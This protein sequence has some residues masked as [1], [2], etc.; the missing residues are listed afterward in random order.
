MAHERVLT[1]D[2][3]RFLRGGREHRIVSAAIHY[4]RIHPDLWRDRLQRLRAMGCNTVECYIAWNFHQPTPAAP[5][6]DGWRD[7]AGFV[8]LAG[9]LG[10]DVIARPG[11]YICAEWDFGGLPAWLLAD[12]NVRLRT[13][14]PVYLAAVDAWFDEL[15][16][17]LAELQATR[18]GP[19]VAVQIENEYGSFGADPDYLDHLRK[20]LIERGVDTLLFTSDGPQELMLAG[21][22]VPDV[23]ATVNFGSRADEAFATL[24]RV[25]PDDPPVCMEFWNGWF[26]HF[27]EPHHTRS[28]Q[29]AAR[30]LDEIL[31]AG[32]SVNFY[33]G[34]GGTNFGFWA[35]ANHSGVGTGDPGY[36]P[37]IT[38]YDYDA[39]VGE[40]GELTPKFHLF[41]E[42]VGRYV[43]LPDAQ[44][45]AP[46]PRL[47]PQTVAAPRIAA[48]RD[49]LDLLATDPIHHPTPQPIEKLGH[50]FGLVHYRRR[51]DGPARTHTLRI[52]GVRDRAQVFAD[53]KLLGMVERDIPERTLDLQIPDEGLDLELLVE[54]LGRVNYGPHLAD[55]KGL[56]GG[57]RLDHQF[58][59][60]WE[61]RVLPLD[62]PTGALALENQEAVT[63]N[64]TAGPAFH[65]AAITVRE[66]ADGFLAVPS[67]ARSLVWLNGFL[68]GR[69]W[70][71]GPQ[72]TLYAPAP[73]WRAGANEIVVLALEPDAGTQ[74]PDAQ[75][76]SAPSPDAQGLE[77][78]LR[79]EPDLGPLAT[80]ST[81]ADY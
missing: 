5:R 6:F 78:E 21:G 28:A 3:G 55:R 43:E 22:T 52:E 49:R 56:I 67:T 76:P 48:L 4:F 20:G 25:R 68:L 45:P 17:V 79:G 74:S 71:R 53:G 42:V 19:V 75:S 63:A 80:P 47:M 31:A 59:F 60:G 18:G 64:Q 12:E 23:L 29:D 8:R 61:H 69:L 10:F 32:G 73:L 35:G 14:D 46:L 39:P 77:I 36:Q 11:P 30:S 33:M 72:V 41:R 65:R 9:E 13:T 2:G 81:H 50:G 1:I 70:D 26:D 37:T 58:Q 15:I 24:R 57:V 7:V 62:D 27:G 40:A 34:H 51:L 38:S 54:P 16:P 66:P 44:P